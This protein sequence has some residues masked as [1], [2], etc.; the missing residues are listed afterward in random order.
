MPVEDG[1]AFC[2]LCGRVLSPVES[3]K[4]AT[5]R[6]TLL[7]QQADWSA[8]VVSKDAVISVPYDQVEQEQE[9]EQKIALEPLSRPPSLTPVTGNVSAP[10]SRA[11]VPVPVVQNSSAV[12]SSA[13]TRRGHNLAFVAIILAL[14]GMGIMAGVF[15]IL[16]NDHSTRRQTV[17]TNQ[18][19][20]RSGIAVPGPL[21]NTGTVEFTDQ[22]PQAA[23]AVQ[24]M[25]TDMLTITVPNLAAPPVHSHYA[26]WFFQSNTG[27]PSSQIIFHALGNLSLNGSVYTLRFKSGS[28]KNSIDS[29]L[30]TLGNTLQ[31]TEERDLATPANAP[32]GLVILHAQFPPMAYSNILQ[33][34]NSS[35]VTPD[36][37]GLL[38]TLRT[39]AQ[40]LNDLAH[41]LSTA[42][43]TTT[44]QCTAYNMLTLL[45]G[46]QNPAYK[47]N[48]QTCATK[49][50]PLITSTTHGLSGQDGNSYAE[51]SAASASLAAT[52]P[53]ATPSIQQGARQI[54]M[55]TNNVKVWS[56]ELHSDA[57]SL[58][59]NPAQSM[60]IP[61]IVTL[62]DDIANG[63]DNDH[64]GTIAPV[65]GEAGVEQAYLYAQSM[66]TM[67]LNK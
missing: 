1:A 7:G 49:H 31:I 63:V 66:L 16:Q 20:R 12:R 62:T 34:L 43:D 8:P 42:K 11:L 55:A 54:V 27:A 44:I 39:T 41:T 18:Q 25:G 32:K 26:A 35:A 22:H 52:Q 40:Q 13:S 59:Q 46:Q 60:Y 24:A 15:A 47:I 48:A 33:L 28:A 37:S 29:N 53:D 58:L 5:G 2:G 64:D 67:E 61:H 57:Q 9:Q 38:V 56:R 19:T 30:L 10:V 51:L 23:Q 17:T 4:A 36:H 6:N 14:V 3:H 21:T 65:Q 45:D 50:I